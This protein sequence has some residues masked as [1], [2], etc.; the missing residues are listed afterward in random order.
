MFMNQRIVLTGASTGIG[1]ALAIQLARRGARLVLA[2]RSAEQ[3][4]KVVARCQQAGGQAFAVPTDVVEQDACKNLIEHA[5]E[6]LGGIDTVINNAGISMWARF[7]EVNDLSIFEKLMRVNYLGA[8]Y[9]THYALPHLK[10]SRGL[11]VAISSLTGKTGV[12]TRTGY[13]AS[14]HAMQGFFDSLRIELIG[15]GVDVSV[16]SPG[17]VATDIR[18]HAYRPD[19][20]QRQENPRSETV[21]ENMSVEECVRL[22][23]EAMERRR[24]EL[25]MTRVGKVGLWLKLIAPGVVDRI[26]L[27]QVK[28]LGD[29]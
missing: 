11:L 20:Q 21:G 22:I 27:H 3:L 8:V 6:K 16:I 19:G 17:L 25:V 18:S 23:L 15:T 1:E 13:A 24:R 12:P 14:K 7:D 10:K 28:G 29:P 9:C 2:A 5:V 4:E 26:A